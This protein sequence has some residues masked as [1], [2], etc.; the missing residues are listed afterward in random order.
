MHFIAATNQPF[1]I[2][3]HS[4]F[5]T[6]LSMQNQKSL[7]GNVFKN[8]FIIIYCFRPPTLFTKRI[9]DDVRND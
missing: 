3:E 1:S 4:T 9:A 5:K 6:L 2:V 7:K 8:D